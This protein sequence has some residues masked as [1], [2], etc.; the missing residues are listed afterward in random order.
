[1]NIEG[2]YHDVNPKWHIK[3]DRGC[4]TLVYVTQGKVVYWIQGNYVE[5]EKGEILYIP[6][7]IDRAWENHADESHQKYTVVFTWEEHV[8]KNTLHFTKQNGVYRY[9]TSNTPYYEQRFSTLYT[10]TLWKKPYFELMSEYVL[11]ELFT[12]IAQESSEQRATP[13]KERIA[14]EIEDYL[15]RHFRRNVTIEELADLA[16]V[17]PNYVSVLFK[18]V[19]GNTPIQHLHQIRINT[20]LNLLKNTQ[21]TINEIAEYLGYCDQSYFNRM[22]KKWMGVAPSHIV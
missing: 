19:M 6:P 11:S 8:L 9:K 16:G 18:E 3:K 5:L 10:Q 15:L 1:M 12:Q 21:M 2:V 14:R 13:A 20:A 4:A 17:T 22:F 7:N